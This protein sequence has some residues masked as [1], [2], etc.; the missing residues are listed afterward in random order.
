MEGEQSDS[1]MAKSGSIACLSKKTITNS[2][3]CIISCTIF[4]SIIYI[5]LTFFEAISVVTVDKLFIPVGYISL[6]VLLSSPIALYGSAK[7][8]YCALF[9]FF[10]LASYHLYALV[11]YV[12]LNIRN[13]SLL[14]I[15]HTN[16]STHTRDSSLDELALH[17]VLLAAYSIVVLLSLIMVCLKI[18]SITSQIEPAK[19]ILVDNNPS[20]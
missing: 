6:I 17:H 11:I 2:L 5:I 3:E 16:S 4:V 19:V 8:S 12:W 7:N 14:S 20:E 10:G 9:F 15:S 13:Q 18:I 1:E